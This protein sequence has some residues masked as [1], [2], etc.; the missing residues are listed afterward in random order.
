MASL[1]RIV[2]VNEASRKILGFESIDEIIRDLPRYFTEDSLVVF[3]EELIALAEGR[4]SFDCEIPVLNS[5]RETRFL[6]LSINVLPG[7]EN[8]LSRVLVSFFDITDRKN[9][10]EEK[11]KLEDQLRQAVKMEAVG[12]L[13]GGVAHDFNNMLGVILG[14]VEMIKP[15]L[16]NGDPMLASI[17]QIEKA[18]I[19][20][21]DI[22]RQLLTFSRKQIVSPVVVDLN[23]MIKN[24]RT[25]I[26][27]MI[28]EDIEI[29]FHLEKDLWKL[30]I[31]P[32]QV[33]Q[34]FVNLAVNA[35]DAM[36]GGGRMTIETA[37]V[38]LDDAYKQEHYECKPGDF[39][40]FALSDSG[41]GIDREIQARI[42]DP[43]F[44]TKEM[45]KGTGLGL[46]TVYGIVKQ[47]NG[48]INVYSEPGHGT[49]FKIY[50]PREA[51]VDLS[52]RKYEPALQAATA[53]WTVLLVED[54]DMLRLMAKTM[55]EKIGHKALVTGLPH[56]AIS[57]CKDMENKIDLVLTDVV[58]PGMSGRELRDK[59]ESIR[60]GI[61]VLF[62]S[63]YTSNVIAH[64][65]VLDEDVHFIQKPFRK[66]D[67]ARKIME[68]IDNH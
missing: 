22:T 41:I 44:T 23:G 30:K 46:S 6:D 14:Y 35:R 27:R 20:S 68:V 64:H 55:L 38:I 39:V 33:D 16:P 11:R 32:S 1:I 56:D 50:F 24:L 2:S 65:G 67:L 49:T 4:L 26:T 62:M 43:F 34:I 47:N 36:P 57:M 17:E 48:F 15:D 28:G 9:A 19:H 52:E 21:R 54:D 66:D 37:N 31:D 18:A 59:L 13:A 60:P 45:G 10:D 5:K 8:S 7:F 25:T 58:M 63:G 12:N 53:T 3:K 42:F 61:K 29:E 51:D 40:L